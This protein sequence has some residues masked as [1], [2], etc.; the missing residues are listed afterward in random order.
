M[1][2]LTAFQKRYCDILLL[3]EITGRV[4]QSKALKLAGSKSKGKNLTVIASRT[5]RLVQCRDYMA[6]ARARLDRQTEKT[7]A[8]ILAEYEKLGFSR[9]ADYYNDDGTLKDISSLTDDQK[10]ALSAIEI[11]E[12]EYENK[13]GRKG[14]TRKI[15]IRLHSKKGALDSLARIKGLMKGDVTDAVNTLAKAIKDANESDKNRDN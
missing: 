4:N 12:H 15:K 2:K 5:A 8:E 3:M 14:L 13:K 7:N 6:R 9:L 11:E 1:N 10:S